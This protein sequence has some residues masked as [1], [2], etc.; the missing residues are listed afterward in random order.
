MKQ[1]FDLDRS[2]AFTLLLEYYP[3]WAAS[4]D[5]G[6]RDVTRFLDDWYVDPS[7][8]MA[9]FARRWVTAQDVPPGGHDVGP[10]GEATAHRAETDPAAIASSGNDGRMAGSASGPSGAA[11]PAPSSTLDKQGEG[12]G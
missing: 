11:G 4:R 1:R 10:H 12:N 2:V 9:E 7:L 6:G 5:D 8:D 3:G